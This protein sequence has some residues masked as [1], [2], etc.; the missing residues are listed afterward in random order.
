MNIDVDFEPGQLG[1]E[2][3]LWLK[4]FDIFITSVRGLRV[5]AQRSN[6]IGLEECKT[7]RND[8]LFHSCRFSYII[9][10]DANNK[11]RRNQVLKKD[12]FARTRRDYKTN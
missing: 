2:Y 11:K 5:Y 7:Q 9:S 4:N 3:F 10:K 12:L 1:D 8:I 6:V